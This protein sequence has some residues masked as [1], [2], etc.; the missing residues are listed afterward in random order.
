M[1]SV[2]PMP[3]SAGI[4]VG[5]PGQQLLP[6]YVVKLLKTLK[7]PFGTDRS[8]GGVDVDPTVNLVTHIF[9]CIGALRDVNKVYRAKGSL[10]SRSVGTRVLFGFTAE[11]GNILLDSI[12]FDPPHDLLDSAVYYSQIANA[13]LNVFPEISAQVTPSTGKVLLH[14]TALK[15]SSIMA[16]ESLKMV[17][18]AFPAGA[19]TADK[20]GALPLHWIT[21]NANCT[22]EMIN[23]LINANPKAPWVA[24]ADGYLPL[25]WAV[26]QDTPNIDVVAALITANPSAASKACNKGSLPIHWCINRERPHLGV[27]RALVQVRNFCANMLKR[28]KNLNLLC[29]FRS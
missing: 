12:T 28:M 24:D 8:M 4:D 11:L 16:I 13:I 23:Y 7:I 10:V 1:A 29:F 15:T 26:N 2:V 19:W 14:H 18:K 25:H 22:P 27:M 9:D 20:S 21:H 3:G 6:G 17:L 5:R